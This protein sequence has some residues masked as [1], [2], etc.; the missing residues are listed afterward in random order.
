MKAAVLEDLNKL[1]VKEVPTPKAGPGEILIKVKA[2]AVCG[3]DLRIMKSGNPR[4]KF[5]Q[6]IGHEVSGIVEKVGEG[7]TKYKAGDKICLGADVPCGVCHWCTSGHGNNCPINYAIGYQ[8]PGGFA[9]YMLV[10]KTTIDF[11]PVA[12]IPKELDFESAALAE[13]LACAINGLEVVNLKHG[14]S[15]VFIGTGPI[16]CM[17]IPLARHMGATKVIA[18]DISED[19]LKMAKPFDADHYIDSSRVDVVE[20]VKK[21]TDG[22]GAHKVVTTCGA[23]EAHE[24]A[25]AMVRNRGWVN[26]FGG[27]GKNVRNLSVPSNLIHYKECVVTGSHGCVPR[28][29]RI[30]LDFITAGYIPAEKIIT[31]RFTLD[32]IHKAFKYS[33][34]RKGIKAVVLP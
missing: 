2:C 33:E 31:G 25:I 20:M 5:P 34:Q 17:M 19:R 14:D 32:E 9:E 8:F 16:G 18:C 27:L 24:Q 21:L 15:I 13:P 11:G 1:V 28:Q 26:L 23:V 10:N 7:V 29:H 30:A 4:V 3:S 6:I 12:K 22:I